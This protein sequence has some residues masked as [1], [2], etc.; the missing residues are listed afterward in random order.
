MSTDEKLQIFRGAGYITAPGLN[1]LNEVLQQVED[2]PAAFARA[3]GMNLADAEA[4]IT[5]ARAYWHEQNSEEDQRR[6][7]KVAQ[8]FEAAKARISPD[9]PA[10]IRDAYGSAIDPAETSYPEDPGTWVKNIWKKAGWSKEQAIQVVIWLAGY[11]NDPTQV[12]WVEVQLGFRKTE[13]PTDSVSGWGN[14]YA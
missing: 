11:R 5:S 2:N 10:A 4:F 9:C 1:G 6:S 7:R 12:Y 14:A 13:D 8:E 3:A